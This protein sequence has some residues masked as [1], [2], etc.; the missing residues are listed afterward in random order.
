MDQLLTIIYSAVGIIITGLATWGVAVLTK[1]LNSKIKDKELANFLTTLTN[2][3]TSVVKEV[4]QTYVEALKKEGSFNK[5]AQAI[6]LNKAI[7]L[8]KSQLTTEL[9]TFITDNYGDIEA[10]LK[11]QIE[12]C[13]YSLKK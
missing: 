7:T 4:Y 6:A 9:K 13:I 2:I 8:A 3:I 1:W 11:M 10:W 5:D 12:A